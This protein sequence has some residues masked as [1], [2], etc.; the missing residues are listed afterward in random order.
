LVFPEGWASVVDPAGML[1]HGWHSDISEHGPDADAWERTGRFV[2]AA[3]WW[4][5]FFLAVSLLEIGHNRLMEKR[6]EEQSANRL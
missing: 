2:L 4:F 5:P 1:F 6:L 3:A